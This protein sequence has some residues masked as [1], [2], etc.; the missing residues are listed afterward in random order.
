MESYTDVAYHAHESCWRCS[1]R[2]WRLDPPG[3]GGWRFYCP[4]C[5]HL[6]VTCAEAEEALRTLSAG[7]VGVVV[8]V[9]YALRLE[10]A[11]PST[12]EEREPWQ[13]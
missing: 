10:P 9:P 13:V 1:T 8:A 7:A 5:Q 6:T 11:A 12:T 4:T 2:L 3:P